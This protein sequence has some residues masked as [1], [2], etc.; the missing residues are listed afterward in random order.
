MVSSE[1][2][3]RARSLLY[4]QD[5]LSSSSWYARLHRLSRNSHRQQDADAADQDE[6][7]FNGRREM[8]EENLN[9]FSQAMEQPSGDLERASML[10]LKLLTIHGTRV[11]HIMIPILPAHRHWGP[12]EAGQLR[13]PQKSSF[14]TQIIIQL[15]HKTYIRVTCDARSCPKWRGQVEGTWAATPR[16]GGFA[17]LGNTGA[18]TGFQLD[19]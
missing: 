4:I 16:G 2:F 13:P 8:M 18:R 9:G 3:S 6:V 19:G 11:D 7:P 12:R 15:T 5:P 1:N 17:P 10:Q 14:S